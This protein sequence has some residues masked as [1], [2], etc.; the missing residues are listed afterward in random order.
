MLSANSF[1]LESTSGIHFLH[2]VEG[3][4]NRYNGYGTI[5]LEILNILVIVEISLME[6]HLNLYIMI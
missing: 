4:I 5:D 6:S 2:C 1:I 3:Q